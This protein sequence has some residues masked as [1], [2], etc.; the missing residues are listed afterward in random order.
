MTGLAI[1]VVIIGMIVIGG[2]VFRD[3]LT[4]NAGELKV[5]DCFDEPVGAQTVKDVQH[6]P[7]SESHTAEIFYSGNMP[8]AKGAP[9]PGKPAIENF[10]TAACAPAFAS[11]IDRTVNTDALDVGYLAPLADGW[12]SGDRGVSCYVTTMNRA[13]MTRSLKAA[14][15]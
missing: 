3:R 10:V 9:F 15:N 12:K 8:D 5:G 14:S 7:C 4:G 2:V 6:H 13:P 11:F 1:R